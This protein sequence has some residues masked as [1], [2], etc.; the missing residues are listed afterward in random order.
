MLIQHHVLQLEIP[1]GPA[2]LVE[3][4]HSADYL[5]EHA[6]GLAFIEAVAGLDEVEGFAVYGQF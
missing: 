2:L 4:L 6:A 1:V 3:V 5:R